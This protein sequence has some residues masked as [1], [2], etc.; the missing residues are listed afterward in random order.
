MENS[1]SLRDNIEATCKLKSII[2]CLD[3]AIKNMEDMS[4]IPGWEKSFP[5]EIIDAIRSIQ[6]NCAKSIGS[7]MKSAEEIQRSID[8]IIKKHGL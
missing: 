6:N 1:S 7:S 8:K 5:M 3:I 2:D 4:L